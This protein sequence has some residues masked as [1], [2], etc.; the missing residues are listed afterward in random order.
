MC[1]V[2]I[3]LIIFITVLCA[4]KLIM[5]YTFKKSKKYW[6]QHRT[7]HEKPS[8][9]FGNLAPV[10]LGKISMAEYLQKIYD[11]YK[12]H[13]YV[14]IYQFQ[15]PALILRDIK[16]I[17]EITVKEFEKFPQHMLYTS[18]QADPI[19]AHNLFAMPGNQEWKDLRATLSPAFTSSKL[20]SLFYLIDNC[21]QSFTEHL[22]ESNEFVK[23]E[24]KEAFARL[25][26]DIIA[27]TALGA[28]CNSLKNPDND[29]FK[30]GVAA[31]NIAKFPKSLKFFINNISPK[32][33]KILKV[34]FINEEMRLFFE[35]MIQDSIKMRENSSL[36]RPDIIHL[37]ME[38]RKGQLK[39]DIGSDS[40]T[41]IAAV[42][43]S[44]TTF[45]EKSSKID[46][47]DDIMTAQAVIFFLAGFDTSSTAMSF[48]A[49]ELALH[50][51]IQ[52]R[53]VDNIHNTMEEE[54]DGKLSYKTVTSMK[55]LDMVVAEVLRKWPPFAVTDRTTTQS[56]VIAPVNE[57][58]LPVP[59][60]KDVLCL[61]P[62]FAIHRDP[63][64][65][66]NPEDFNPDRFLGI[67]NRSLAFL[68]FGSGRRNC[69]GSRFAL[70]EIKIVLIRI[71]L[72]F[73]IV[74][75]DETPIPIVLSKTNVN[76]VSD[77]GYWLGLK[78]RNGHC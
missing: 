44:R 63:A 40:I 60:S 61:I 12:T 52:Q 48:A 72:K 26:N 76:P 9:F 36:V 53:V 2:H 1:G 10:I 17:N 43:E 58:E 38:A 24:M 4:V 6:E 21:A 23:L 22:L 37:L 29:I 19:W 13:R 46:I 65:F 27:S 54:E 55:Y 15:K 50:P 75:I 39:V 51:H 34:R 49:Y 28:T 45:E 56:Y 67:S 35:K 11:R 73:E 31:C 62:I 14:G 18:A 16:L 77:R 41:E 59:I 70:L 20:K 74:P 33:A 78:P 25:T 71:L 30:M 69:I 47:T 8:F 3:E 5:H 32:L 7:P 68:P 64:L 66:P 57:G 42:D